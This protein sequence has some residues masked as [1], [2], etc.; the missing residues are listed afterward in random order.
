M[1]LCRICGEPF[2]KTVIRY[3]WGAED[4]EEVCP[5]C[6]G[7]DYIEAAR[8]KKCGKWSNWHEFRDHFFC[9]E[10][11]DELTGTLEDLFKFSPDCDEAR[12]RE[13]MESEVREWLDAHW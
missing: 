2:E 6:G 9:A 10:C 12:A 3:G 4:V 13:Q 11:M 1:Y 7:K 8:C 5:H